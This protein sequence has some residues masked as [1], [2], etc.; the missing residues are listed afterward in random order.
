M[1][2][3]S[4]R[5]NGRVHSSFLIFPLK[6]DKNQHESINA[7]NVLIEQIIRFQETCDAFQKA[8]TNKKQL[9]LKTI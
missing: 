2:Y 8:L 9:L 1:T 3:D 6:I 7:T 5:K 4:A